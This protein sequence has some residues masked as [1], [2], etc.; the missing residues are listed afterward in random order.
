MAAQSTPDRTERFAGYED[1]CPWHHRQPFRDG[2][3]FARVIT[4][5]GGVLPARVCRTGRN[6]SGCMSSTRRI[7]AGTLFVQPGDGFEPGDHPGPEP[8]YCLGGQLE[9]GNPDTAGWITLEQGDA[10]NIPA[11]A[12]HWARNIGDEPAEII[13]WVPGEMHTDEWKQ[14]IDEGRGK[15]YEREPVTLNG[16]H[17]RNEGFRR[18]WMTSKVG[19][20]RN[21]RM[22]R[23][24]CSTFRRDRPGCT[25]KRQGT[26]R[27][28]M[29]L[30]SFFYCDERI[31]CAQVTIPAERRVG[32]RVG[33]LRAAALRR[34]G[35]ALGDAG[36][37][38]DRSGGRAGRHGLPAAFHPALP[39]GDRPGAR[40]RDLPPGLWQERSACS[41]SAPSSSTVRTLPV[42]TDSI[43]RGVRSAS[44][45]PRLAP[46]RRPR[47]APALD[48]IQPASPAVSERRSRCRRD[49]FLRSSCA[50]SSRTATAWLPR[51]VL[52][53]TDTAA[54]AVRDDA[55]RSR[56]AAWP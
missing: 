56:R 41:L 44:L 46:R 16:P 19:R 6:P 55:R 45:P 5:K 32:A 54:T 36:R 37:H 30:V 40:V 11:L 3:Q 15:W 12:H 35:N 28:R 24:T 33:R 39:P 47:R 52:V 7:N 22:A 10:A 17:D 31:R 9:L 48:G 27:R 50:T 34:V 25:P 51:L 49:T 2:E 18:I 13:W 53:S 1:L 38:W 29:L 14:K 42:G 26:D 23:S 8:Y 43:A 20:P 21:P 4:R